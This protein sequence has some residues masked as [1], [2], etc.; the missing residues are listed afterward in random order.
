MGE[1]EMPTLISLEITKGLIFP[2][3]GVRGS[4]F[5]PGVVA[6]LQKTLSRGQIFRSPQH[7]PVCKQHAGWGFAHSSAETFKTRDFSVWV[8]VLCNISLH[9][10][11]P[12]PKLGVLPQPTS[13]SS[14]LQLT[15]S[16]LWWWHNRPLHAAP[17][18]F[19]GLK[20]PVLGSQWGFPG[21]VGT[22]AGRNLGWAMDLHSQWACL[23]QKCPVMGLVSWF[24]FLFFFF[25]MAWNSI[26]FTH[27]LA[28]RKA[29]RK[30]SHIRRF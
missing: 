25:S 5:L 1:A 8:S 11:K 17:G 24:Y 14:S 21:A 20:P 18:G 9:L 23:Q 16:A 7:P 28:R 2:L 12:L 19:Y 29:K 22:E 6:E 4:Q 15:A 3:A 27:G 13:N 26:S 30:I 10:S